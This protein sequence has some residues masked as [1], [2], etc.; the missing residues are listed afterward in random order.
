LFKTGNLVGWNG[1]GADRYSNLLGKNIYGGYS[2]LAGSLLVSVRIAASSASRHAAVLLSVH[3][4]PSQMYYSL[5]N[6]IKLFPI[7]QTTSPKN[8]TII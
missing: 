3:Y 4:K 1:E 5:N 2:E 6:V 7:N 8:C